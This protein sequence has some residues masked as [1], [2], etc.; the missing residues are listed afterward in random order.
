M[1]K[2]SDMEAGGESP[3]QRRTILVVGDHPVTRLGVGTLVS[4]QPDLE[5][6]GEAGGAPAAAALVQKLAPD[7]VIVDLAHETM[8]GIELIKNLKALRPQTKVLV[9]SM[10]DESVLA[11]RALRAGAGGYVMKRQ[12]AG[13][14]LAAIRR[15]LAGEVSLSEGMRERML[16]RIVRSPGKDVVF[17]IDTL[18][19]REIEVLQLIGSG[20]QTR[21]I[22]DKLLLSVKTIDSHRENLRRK[23]GIG[24][25]PDLVRHAIQWA[26]SEQLA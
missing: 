17:S 10:Q 9:M 15:V 26:R 11:E 8:G 7:L 19:D 3:P 25:G 6:C 24:R 23:L 13:D 12:P 5:V 22:A 1:K 16:H 20:Y 18:T 14:I 4:R 2:S 21:Q